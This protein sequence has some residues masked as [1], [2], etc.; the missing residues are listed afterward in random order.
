MNLRTPPHITLKM[1]K[2]KENVGKLELKVGMKLPES[3]TKRQRAKR[4]VG[5]KSVDDLLGE[6]TSKEQKST[7]DILQDAE[8]VSADTLASINRSVKMAQ[9]TK[10]LGLDM[11][12]SLEEQDEKLTKVQRDLDDIEDI[13]QRNE[14]HLNVID[15]PLAPITNKFKRTK[16]GKNVENTDKLIGDHEKKLEGIKKKE[17]KVHMKENKEKE[18]RREK[19][20]IV[21]SEKD[22]RPDL[23]IL[24]AQAQEN[25]NKTDEGLRVMEGLVSDLMDVG[26][27]LR[28]QIIEQDIRINEVNAGVAAAE[29]KGNAQTKRVRRAMGSKT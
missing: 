1:A 4:A 22:A 3:K 18:K 21:V 6:T 13:F 14:K 24:S 8:D 5:K 28:D 12:D 29:A 11:V 20:G 19:M 15:N 10:K 25:V 2:N 9:T 27:T 17:E 23:S 16:H 26:L 7:E